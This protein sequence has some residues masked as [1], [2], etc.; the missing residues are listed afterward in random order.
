MTQS[1]LISAGEAS[2]DLHAA[3]L[4]RELKKINSDLNITAMGGDNLREAGADVII[5]CAELAVVG[6]V[7]VLINYRKIKKAL[8]H[9]ADIVRTQKPDLLIL[10]D[11]QEFNMKLAQ[12]AKE[13]GVKVLF[14]IGPQVWAWRPK[15]VHKIRERVD[16]MA[17]LFPFEVAFYENANVPVKFVGNPL[18]DEVYPTKDKPELLREYQLSSDKKTI[19]LF[20]GSRRSEIKKVL[21]IQL[22]TAK[23]L[24]EQRNDLQFVLGVASTLDINELKSQCVGYEALNIQ[25]IQDRPYNIMST[26]D[27]IITAS[28][29]ATL[30][31]GL[32]GI[33]FTITYRISPISYA[34]FK[35]MISV[36]NVGLVNIVAEK[37]IINEF[38][39]DKAQPKQIGQEIM[40]I[41]DDEAYRNDM[42][43]QLSEVRAKLGAEG[44]S[45]NVASLAANMLAS[46]NR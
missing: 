16:M 41:L 13:S 42:I 5:D 45:K 18:V 46:N 22:K 9:L 37:R 34:I 33:P 8:D 3:N 35:R 40:R 4:V 21:P 26:C 32:M 30:E 2:G 25:F 23:Y 12:V 19:G 31:I 44:G 1:V 36:E 29:T 24:T 6:L 39:Q 10:V 28:G 15:R 38:I 17:V 43:N 14:Y 20:P 27:A 7:E 11:Y